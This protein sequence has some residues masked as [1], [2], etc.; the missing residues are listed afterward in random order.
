[1]YKLLKEDNILKCW[2]KCQGIYKVQLCIAW[3]TLS[4]LIG[5][6]SRNWEG[7]QE[8]KS[9]NN[10]G[11]LFETPCQVWLEMIVKMAFNNYQ[12]YAWTHLPNWRLILLF[13]IFSK[14]KFEDWNNMSK[15]F[16]DNFVYQ[17]I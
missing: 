1:M 6:D 11:A 2:M 12:W 7:S 15:P 3:D 9:N 8:K 10:L 5:Y 4:S 17:D 13:Q 16:V 14:E